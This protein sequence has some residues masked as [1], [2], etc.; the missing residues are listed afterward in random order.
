MISSAA[1]FGIFFCLNRSSACAKLM[2]RLRSSI[3]ARMS[4]WLTNLAR[5]AQ[6]G[7]LAGVCAERQHHTENQSSTI[8]EG[9]TVLTGARAPPR[10]LPAQW[11][12]RK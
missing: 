9:H 11:R 8:W 4:V 3:G 10:T 6:M 7:G 1:S 12:R 2:S 5:T